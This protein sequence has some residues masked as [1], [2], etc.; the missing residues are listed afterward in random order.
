[1]D[2]KVEQHQSRIQDLLSQTFERHRGNATG[3]LANYIPELAA[4]DPEKFGIAIA[5][6]RGAAHDR[7]HRPCVHDPVGVEGLRLLPRA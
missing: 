6:G 1:M 4:V 2:A 5:H 7:R 3:Q